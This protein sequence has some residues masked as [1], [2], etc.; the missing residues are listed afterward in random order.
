MGAGVI[1]LDEADRAAVLPSHEHDTLLDDPELKGIVDLAG[2]LCE[3]PIALV[4]IVETNRQRFL[5]RRGLEATETPRSASFC[6]YAMICDDIYE[7]RDAARDPLFSDNVLVTG[8]PHIRFYAGAPLISDDGLR[9]GALCII[10]SVPRSEGLDDLQREAL[11]ILARAVMR[12]LNDRRISLAGER[13]QEALAESR[14]RFD[15]LADAIPQMAWSTTSEGKTDYFNAR[16]A[17]F[18]GTP[19]ERHLNDGWIEALHP[20]DVEVAV[21]AW[22]KAVQQVSPYEVEYRVRHNDGTHRWTLARG[23]PMKDENGKVA[24]WFGT[25]T[26]IH[27]RRMLEESRDLLSRE[28]SHRIKNIFSVVAGLISFEARSEP[29]LKP[30]ADGL[31]ERIQALGRAH[32]Y[33]RPQGAGDSA[34]RTMHGMLRELFAAYSDGED[35]RV[36]LGGSDLPVCETATTPLALIFHE[37]ATN[38]VKYGALATDDGTVTLDIDREGETAVMQWRENG[39]PAR[40]GTG[41]PNF[42]SSLID[43]S[44]ERQLRGTLTRGW[45]DGFTATIRVPL[46]SLA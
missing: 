18:T 42:G 12:R 32:D 11:S 17:E 15:A 25:N 29:A 27:D 1:V 22:S 16:W 37:L 45:D 33:V 46:A 39:G 19:I 24:R 10:D 6:Q 43:M 41:T 26:D 34:S 2:K 40:D 4:S 44:I 38:A 30:M 3:A 5:A 31:R 21:A 35:P 13:A 20:E 23:L 14:A 8:E 7:V 9:L 36:R 28:L